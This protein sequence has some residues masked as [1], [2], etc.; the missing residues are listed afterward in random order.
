MS[1]RDFFHEAVKN[2][3]IKD[4][5]TITHDPFELKVGGVDMAIDLGAERMLAAEKENRK[6]AVEIKSF[7]SASEIS[8]FHGALGQFINYRIGLKEKEPARQLY[9][10]VPTD[11]YDGFFQLPLVKKSARFA[12]LKLIIY[13]PT[14]E[15]I[16]KWKE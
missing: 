3:L 13:Q 14:S 6:I 1:K 2:A 4:G 9:L 10:A 11:V 7:L 15:E 5:W 8:E 16:V 12:K